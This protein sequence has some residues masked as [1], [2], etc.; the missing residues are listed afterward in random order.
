M[1]GMTSAARILLVGTLSAAALGLAPDR[2]QA[3]YSAQVEAGTL[4]LHGNAA[5]D[6]L[7]LRLQPGSPGTLQADIGADGTAEFSFDR[8]TFSS[9]E[10]EAG[11]GD[12]E[13]RVDQSGGTF[14]DESITMNGGSGDDTLIGG[15]GA[16]IFIGGAGEDFA[17]GNIGADQASMG[18]GADR[19]Q[20]DPGDGSDTVDGQGG[21]DQ[22]D[23][24]A[25]NAP[26]QIELSA[27][28]DRVR[29]TRNVGAITMDLDRIE[30][31]NLR[32]LGGADTVTVGD[33]SG[34]SVKTVDVDL[35]AIAGGDDGQADTVIARGSDV[36]D[37]VTFA[38]PDGRPV[39]NGLG[40]QT[41]VTGGE[42]ALDNFVAAMLGGPDA[43]IMSVGVASAIPLHMDGG[44]GDD[45]AHY[46]GTAGPD[47]IALLRNGTE[48]AVDNPASA[49]FETANVE[50]M[51][52]AGLDGDDTIAAGNGLAA[53]T[54]LRLEGG[55]D[56]D[57]LRGGDGA[58]ILDGGKGDDSVDGNIGADQASL[59]AGDDR[60]QWD[61]GDGSDTVDG[62]RGNDQLDFNASNAPEQIELSA[63]AG[64]ARLTRNVGAITMDFDGVEHV[65]LRM[66]GGTDTV[67]VNDLAGTG[68]KSV[69]VDLGAIV[70]GG[71]G[72]PDS[73]VVNGTDGRDV[74]HV[75][76][77]GD[78][79]AIAGLAAE[80]R[81]AGSEG[82]NDSLR[83]QTL[84]GN[85][86]V[87]IVP[88]VELLITP[89]VNL[90]P[91]E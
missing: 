50:S 1:N 4:K 68:V 15:A 67:T 87:T 8:S 45:T 44:D 65:N 62:Q 89:V 28:A 46:G 78:Q 57:D 66:L 49:L 56:N 90:G 17:D 9:I 60:F 14:T 43:A 19:F 47:Q 18:A 10:V 59:G 76:R 35:D 30:Q 33:L 16:E 20:W 12:D 31:V 81:I 88:D 72:V 71:D 63:N 42:A 85:D 13:V 91:D 73:V 6:T 34:L 21:N 26:E 22:L 83:L 36:A 5:D 48:V 53:L 24:N 70:G 23:F 27:N 61:P 51:I 38:S 29:L 52:V 32:M 75:T 11:S 25:S 69:D 84:G 82:L 77:S 55:D 39:V 74:L 80:I 79:V 58:D 40:A 54:S 86:D 2:A 7:V 3:A 37:K 64:R 41:R